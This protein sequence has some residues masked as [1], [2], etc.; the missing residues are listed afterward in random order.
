MEEEVGLAGGYNDDGDCRKG[1]V[2][3][4]VQYNI[5]AREGRG[6]RFGS[7]YQVKIDDPTSYC[8]ACLVRRM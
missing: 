3:N 4:I 5:Y 8:T 2:H 7:R 6:S 1:T